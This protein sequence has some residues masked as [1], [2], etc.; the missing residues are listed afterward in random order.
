MSEV[1][2]LAFAGSARRDSYNKKLLRFAANAV[3][4]HGGSVT[5]IDLAEYP[6]PIFDEDL[7]S[8]QGPPENATKLFELFVAHDALLI[9]SPEYNSSVTAL[10]KNTIDWVSRPRENQ[11]MLAA[12]SGKVA[13]LMAASPGGFGGMR[14]LVHLRAILGNIG[15]LVVPNQVAVSKAHEAF[16]DEGDLINP[17]SVKLVDSLA[18][19]L[20]RTA[21][22]LAD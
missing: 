14:G 4:E 7:E 15:M 13:G 10:L 1:K 12:F 20:V 18:T 5:V 17:G 16:N 3:E 11:P 2:V 8:S 21:G 19:A 6:L 22:R 9:A